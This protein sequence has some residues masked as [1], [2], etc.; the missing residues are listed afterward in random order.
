MF[1]LEPF[2]RPGPGESWSTSNQTNLLLNIHAVIAGTAIG[3]KCHA[4]VPLDPARKWRWEG[5][6]RLRVGAVAQDIDL[7]IEAVQLGS[8][9]KQGV[10]N[11]KDMVGAQKPQAIQACDWRA[12]VFLEAAL[13]FLN[14]LCHVGVYGNLKAVSKLANLAP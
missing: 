3:S 11:Q 14:G 7:W 9:H 13:S 12:A 5:K 4:E 1:G 6:L 8:A 10:H 2:L